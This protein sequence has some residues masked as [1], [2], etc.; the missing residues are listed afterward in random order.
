MTRHVSLEEIPGGAR[1]EIFQTG[2]GFVHRWQP[3]FL[4]FSIFP[5][6][7]HQFKQ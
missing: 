5:E 3:A 4:H 6:L 2:P 7:M 1:Y